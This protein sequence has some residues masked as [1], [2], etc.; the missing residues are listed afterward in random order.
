LEKRARAFF[1]DKG[2]L[3]QT[4]GVSMDITDRKLGEEALASLGR[5]LIEAHEEERTWIARELHDDVNQ[6]LALLAIELDQWK[7]HGPETR[8]DISV[9]VQHAQQRLLDISRD[10]QALSHRLHSSK[11]EYLGLAGAANSYCKEFCEQY[12][13]KVEFSHSD[14]PRGLPGEVSL[15]L[16]RV[17]QEALQNALKHSHV[18]DFKVD[19]RAAPGEISLTVT[20]MG[21]GFDQREA[22]N[23]RG[24][25]IISMRERLQLVNGSFTI[26]S[27]PGCG[28]IVRARVPIKSEADRLSMAG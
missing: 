20:D 14:I 8:V 28:T 13:V 15:V 25:G 21:K 23:R 9:H 4:V 17:L 22:M 27:E 6:R 12:N 19:L 11:L 1:D 5:K 24:L 18:K 10:V 2:T 26:E 3:L 7:Q 16:F